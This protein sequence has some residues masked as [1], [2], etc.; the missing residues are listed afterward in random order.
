[1]GRFKYYVQESCWRDVFVNFDDDDFRQ[2]LE[3]EVEE[4]KSIEEIRRD[5]RDWL[6]QSDDEDYGD[7]DDYETTDYDYDTGGDDSVD[8][9]VDEFLEDLDIEDICNKK[10]NK[11][12]GDLEDGW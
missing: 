7:A 2:F 11:V 6:Q 5:A 9:V 1:M 12:L 10:V 3:E 8:S 4:G